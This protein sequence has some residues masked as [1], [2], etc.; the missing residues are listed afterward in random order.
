M[1]SQLLAVAPTVSQTDR[2]KHADSESLE[3]SIFFPY[4]LFSLSLSERKP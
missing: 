3:I 2:D 4:I 1:M